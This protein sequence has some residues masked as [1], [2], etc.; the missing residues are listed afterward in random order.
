MKRN[1]LITL[2]F[3]IIAL[4]LF[5]ANDAIQQSSAMPAPAPHKA[6]GSQAGGKGSWQRVWRMEGELYDFEA[7]DANTIMGVGADGMILSSMDGGTYWHYAAPVEGYDLHALTASTNTIWA[8]G[9]QGVIIKSQDG[10]AVWEQLSSGATDTINDIDFI[11]SA[12][13][14]IVGDNGLL[15]HSTDG[16]NTWASQPSDVTVALN[17]IKLF[18]DGMH[19]VA[20]GNNGVILVTSNGGDSW[21]EKTGVALATANLKD[22]HIFGSKIWVV[23]SDG[24]VYFSA[25]QGESWSILASLWFPMTRI[26]MAPGQDQ[27]GWLVGLDGR[28]AKT[29]NGGQSWQANHGD[30]GYPIYA[31]GL[32]DANHI[33][34]GGS[35]VA[36]SLGNWGASPDKHSWFIWRSQDGGAHWTAPISGLYPWFY[37][38][39][40]VTSQD[41][42]VTG[43]DLQL[44]KTRD[45]GYSWRE[46]HSEIISNSAIVPKGADIRGKMLHAI[47][48][49]PGNPDDCHASGREALLIH[50]QDGGD[51]WT[52]E[53]VDSQ[54]RSLYDI[55][56]TSAASGITV[57]RD[58]NFFTDD[59]NHW[60][61]SFDNGE[62]MTNLDLD[63][64]NSWQG[65]VS[66]KKNYFRYTLDAGRH[67]SGY[68]FYNFGA[69]YNSGADALDINGDGKLDYAWLAGC[70]VQSSVDGPC[71]QSAIIFNPDALNDQNGWRALLL[72]ENTPRLQKIEMVNEETG[73][74]VGFDG[75]ILFT[76]DSGVTWTKQEAHTDANLYG[77]DVYDRNLAYAVGLRGDIIRY[78]EPDRRLSAN[79]QWLNHIDGSLEEWNMMNIRH[80]NSDDVDSIIGETPAPQNL[81]ANMRMRWDDKG[82][83]LALDVTDATLSANGELVD[84]IGIALDGL[85]DGAT[86]ADDHVFIFQADGN[87]LRDGEPMSAQD[88]AVRT[89]AAGY[90]IEA[91]IPQA[92]LGGDFR[93]LR[94][95]GVNIALFDAAPGDS[96]YK[97]QLFW[98]GTSLSADPTTFGSLT[99]FQF[100]RNQPTQKSLAIGEITID[101]NLDDWSDK[102]TYHLNS[103]SADS[104][105]GGFPANAT[106]LSAD[107]RM[108]W[109]QDYLFLGV[110]ASDDALTAGDS[111]E[112]AFDV[113]KDS[114][115]TPPDIILRIWPDGRVTV[116]GEPAATILAKGVITAQGYQLE[117]AIPATLLGGDFSS[118]QLLHF[119]Y[120]LL[121]FDADEDAFDTAMTWQ[122]ASAAGVRADYGWL[123]L[124]PAT[125]LVKAERNDPRF[126]DTFIN[127]WAQTTNYYRLG[128]M[129]IRPSAIESPLIRFDIASVV[130]E[131]AQITLSY[132]GLFTTDSRDNSLFTARIY[133][134]LRNWVEAQA[135]WVQA[136]NGQ[137]WETPGAKGPDDRAQTATDEKQLSFAS[138]DGSCG[139]RNA[140]WFEVTNDV[141]NF[142]AGSETNYGWTLRGEAGA[143]INYTLASSQ[144]N[145]P[146]CF[147][148]MY[149]EYT[150]PSGVV[151]TPTPAPTPTPSMQFLYLPL[152]APQTP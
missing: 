40:A 76:E 53:P 48:C 43:Q 108:R 151:P 89:N 123:E 100:D 29:A 95:L 121:D 87:A 136:A 116:N 86:G 109:W 19:G 35:V 82:L 59:G 66:T 84:K 41:A 135:T 77:L 25:D 96:A 146:D 69:F 138:A 54:G 88:F 97:S 27:V 8:A 131:N 11:G 128:T 20:V 7:I 16:G 142:V 24:Q 4:S 92:D 134:M 49:A 140:T 28:I 22:C 32:G 72:D 31:L 21:Q 147:P 105:Q 104:I 91:F 74:A 39:S 119:D 51:T 149:F 17:A 85:R 150:F 145:N 5:I 113:D 3:V 46:I 13:G 14:W 80:V 118:R 45:G 67:W 102:E 81:D 143:Q 44:L 129:R 62:V 68:F 137:A 63:M 73:W 38:V 112:L 57:S 107:F 55:V 127:E 103:G 133:R 60:D 110:T 126:Q 65:V 98:T 94:K 34:V 132:L 23:G 125:A 152:V 12:T 130:P 114:R 99:L 6:G 90:T 120:G 141:A 111:V 30:E 9:E 10:G 1:S 37:N 58:Y 50:T 115:L 47:S 122:G 93:H 18:D 148:E 117:A 70:T 64:I 124:T 79:P 106:D 71:L 144:N 33:W 52:R 2:L 78:T 42:Y 101:G 61:G 26:E 56:M 83:Y 15:M 75:E 36:E 139:D